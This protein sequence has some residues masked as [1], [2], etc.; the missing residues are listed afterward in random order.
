MSVE[1]TDE[2][3]SLREASWGHSDAASVVEEVVEEEAEEVSM[4]EMSLE[5]S[6]DRSLESGGRRERSDS[7]DST[8]SANSETGLTLATTAGSSESTV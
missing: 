8:G 6:L 1:E 3:T 7:V 5:M 4:E 2:E